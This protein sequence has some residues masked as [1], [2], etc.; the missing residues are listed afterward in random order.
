[1][2]NLLT[3]ALVFGLGV[4]ATFFYLHH[5]SG[6]GNHG[7]GHHSG[8]V[9]SSGHAKHQGGKHEH[10]EINMPGLQGKD[11]TDQEVN[12]LKEIFR[13]HEGIS[14]RVTNVQNGI[15]TTTEAEDETLREAIVSHVS[16]MVTRLQEGRNPEVIIQS[17]TL[18]A[19][20]DFYDE[21]DT[22]IETT[23]LGVKVV[24]TSSNPKVVRL[25]Q[26]HAAEVSDMANRGM[27]A[28]HERMMGRSH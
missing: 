18:D 5:T 19:L 21:I 27:E 20:F 23:E 14:R 17:P 8:D 1:V 28:V 6:G 16:M 12:D 22:E 24:Q 3:Y 4:A 13:S 26:I 11:T 15:V 2:R 10:D 9:S 7:G 25:L